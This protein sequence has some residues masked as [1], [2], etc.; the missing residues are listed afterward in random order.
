M[1]A[2]SGLGM[3]PLSARAHHSQL[4]AAMLEKMD[5]DGSGG[6]G[7]NELETAFADIASATGLS[8]NGSS[9]DLMARADAD[10]DG[11]LNADELEQ[12]V[13]TAFA[14][15]Q[16]TQAFLRFR[17]QGEQGSGDDLFGKVDADGSGGIDSTE[18]ADLMNRMGESG[19]D[20]AAS[21]RL[22]EQ[23]TDGDGS[24]SATEFEAGRPQGPGG[25]GG[26]G[27]MPPPP[28]A[29][30][31]SGAAS[32][33]ETDPLDTN[34]DGVVSAEERAAAAE[35]DPL[36][37]L[38]QSIDSDGDGQISAK[39]VEGF[40]HQLAGQLQAAAQAYNATATSDQDSGS[41]LSLQA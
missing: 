10:G 36:Q 22:A 16:D 32:S 11:S 27:G 29:G 15:P 23:D 7:Q 3:S 33:T 25:P 24:L 40:V 18:L 28:P 39:E 19:S 26:P 6:V 12:A 41:T 4:K 37:A 20:T 30:G 21:D 35:E 9:T 14:P 31:A 1:N 38:M 13:Q 17:G 5:S 34:G 2:I 8:A